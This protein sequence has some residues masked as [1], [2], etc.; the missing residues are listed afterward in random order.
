VAAYPRN[1][2]KQMLAER[3]T[4]LGFWL[5][6]NS[7]GGTEL[8]AGAGWDWLLLDA[9]H[10]L[11][12]P[13][14]VERHVL[15]ARHGGEAELVVRLP[16]IDPNLVKRLLDGGVRSFMFP[17]V[18]TVEEARLAVAATRYPP[19]G[20]R[21]FSGGHR[22]NRY[23]RDAEYLGSYEDDLCVIVQIE[24]PQAVANITAYG[25]IEGIDAMLIGANDLAANMGHLGDTRHPEV[26]AEFDKAGAAI[27]ATRCAAGFQFFDERA[28][29]LIGRGF[30]LA[31]VAGDINALSRAMAQSLT[32]FG[33]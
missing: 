5:S 4:A 30:T 25:E 2:L 16:E 33:R 11:H 23:G 29:K 21:G 27:M 12:D 22:G 20:I 31:A 26:V 32:S 14:T 10:A 1:R 15:A 6:L 17:F 3:R 8:A 19:K 9:E 18:Q 7:I 28:Q 13:E 24:T